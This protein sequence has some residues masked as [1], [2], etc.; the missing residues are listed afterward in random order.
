MANRNVWPIHFE[1]DAPDQY[2]PGANI[3]GTEGLRSQQL[4]HSI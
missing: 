4:G 3:V 2:K 1:I